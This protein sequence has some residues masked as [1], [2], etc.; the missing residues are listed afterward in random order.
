[1]ES[2]RRTIGLRGRGV[3]PGSVAE[4]KCA[5]QSCV[6]HR[7]P[8]VDS[9]GKMLANR[10]ERPEHRPSA[11]VPNHDR[12]RVRP[13]GEVDSRSTKARP[14]RFDSRIQKCQIVLDRRS[15]SEPRAI[16]ASGALK[17]FPLGV[18]REPKGYDDAPTHRRVVE[19]FDGENEASVTRGIGRRL[20]DASLDLD[21]G[22]REEP[23][24]LDHSHQRPGVFVVASEGLARPARADTR[25]HRRHERRSR[26][27]HADEEERRCKERRRAHRPSRRVCRTGDCNSGAKR[28]DRIE[29]RL[30]A[31]PQ[32]V[33]KIPVRRHG[34]S[35]RMI[36]FETPE[37]V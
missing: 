21:R 32:V 34:D 19:R 33:S 27:T 26:L 25:Q 24:R 1:M 37:V 13:D 31:G 17:P 5:K 14:Q 30:E 29:K 3:E 28:E 7:K 4:Q 9:G 11:G 12:R 10:K 35:P 36:G 15:K 18:G 23:P 22:T 2:A 6:T 8:L 16:S 20:V